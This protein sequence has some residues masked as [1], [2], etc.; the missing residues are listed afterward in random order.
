[1]ESWKRE[2]RTLYRVKGPLRQKL[3]INEFLYQESPQPFHA[4]VREIV[5]KTAQFETLIDYTHPKN[6]VW[7]ITA[8]NR[9]QNFRR[10]TC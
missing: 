2:S 9:E 5:G 7:G 6:N 8:R 4:I 1:M 10:S 3:L